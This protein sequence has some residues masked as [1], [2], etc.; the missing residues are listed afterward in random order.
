[1]PKSGNVMPFPSGDSAASLQNGEGGGTFDDMEM[2]DA[3]IA[4]AEARTDTK[5]TEVLGE[6]KRIETATSGTKTTV[7]ATGIAAVALVVAIFGWGSQMFG[8]GL[9]AQSVAIQAAN[10]A[11]S[12][13]TSRF[14]TLDARYDKLDTQM[15]TILEAINRQTPKAIPAPDKSL[16]PPAGQ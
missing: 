5:F 3:K 14:D 7:I 8:T 4:A 1:M 13:S 12:A 10:A 2:M 15:S 9:N 6:L 11:I 16:T